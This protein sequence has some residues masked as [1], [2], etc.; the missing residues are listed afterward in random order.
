MARKA[1]KTAFRRKP[2]KKQNHMYISWN[3]AIHKKWHLLE[4][5]GIAEMFNHIYTHVRVRTHT[6]I[7]IYIYTYIRICT[8]N[9]LLVFPLTEIENGRLTKRIQEK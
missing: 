2:P 6:N 4:G 7:C 9:D 8:Y 1:S 3:Q 5:M